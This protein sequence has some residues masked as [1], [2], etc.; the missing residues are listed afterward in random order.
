MALP[1]IGS[2]LQG[3]IVGGFISTNQD[4]VATDVLIVAEAS[5]ITGTHDWK[6]ADTETVGT[7]S[8]IDGPSNFAAMATASHPIAA[9]VETTMNTAEVGGYSDWY[10]PAVAELDVLYQELKPTTDNNSTGSAIDNPW[11]VPKRVSG[12]RTTGDPSQ[13]GVTDF[14]SGGAE[15]FYSAA[16]AAST[17]YYAS[18]T[19]IELFGSKGNARAVEFQ[20][21][22]IA[23]WG[24]TS[25]FRVRAIRRVS[26]AALAL[27]GPTTDQE[28]FQASYKAAAS[29]SPKQT[30]LVRAAD[31]QRSIDTDVSNLKDGPKLYTVEAIFPLGELSNLRQDKVF[32]VR[33]DQPGLRTAKNL[34]LKSYNIRSGLPNVPVTCVF[35]G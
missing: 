7:D 25:A 18:S 30:A 2:T 14:Q 19:Q 35:W 29:E 26:V 16:T 15:A 8:L 20:T 32:S 27:T 5:L 23:G 31:V 11:A 13:T 24:K 9:E 12:D 10:I 21:G 3:G 6:N 17:D 4:G 33:D 34:R 22:N 1:A 28:L